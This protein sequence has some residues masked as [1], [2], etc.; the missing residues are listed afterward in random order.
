MTRKL[1]SPYR[2]PK[3]GLCTVTK[4]TDRIIAIRRADGMVIWMLRKNARSV[5]KLEAVA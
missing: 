3:H 5:H 4:V 2:C 1:G